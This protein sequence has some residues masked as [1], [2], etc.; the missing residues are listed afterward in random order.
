MLATAIDLS[1]NYVV[2]VHYIAKLNVASL[3]CQF[4]FLIMKCSG[5]L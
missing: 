4:R 3:M 1:H 5:R 2:K